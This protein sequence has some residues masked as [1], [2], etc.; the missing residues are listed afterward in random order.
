MT[1]GIVLGGGDC[2]LAGVVWSP[3]I[4]SKIAFAFSRVASLCCR[5]STILERNHASGGVFGIEGIA[6]KIVG[7]QAKHKIILTSISCLQRREDP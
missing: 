6:T 2:T 3:L 1:E 4:F 5:N 7:V